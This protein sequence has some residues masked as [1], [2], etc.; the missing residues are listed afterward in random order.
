V[1]TNPLING[2]FATG[3][4]K[5]LLLIVGTLN[6]STFLL[7][8]LFLKLGMQ[9]WSVSIAWLIIS[10]ITFFVRLSIVS[11][12]LKFSFT[13][14]YRNAILQPVLVSL[15]CFSALYF[16]KKMMNEESLLRFFI[17]TSISIFT[18]LLS[19]YFFGITKAEKD[20]GKVFII[21]KITHKRD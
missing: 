20:I 15:V 18:S 2:N 11:K 3:K 14:Y 7:M 4:I 9:P 12:Q 5:K 8:Y 13:K 10:V 6:C 1:F 19:V 17:L 21:N 16:A